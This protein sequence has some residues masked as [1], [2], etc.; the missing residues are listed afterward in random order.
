MSAEFSRPFRLDTLGIEPRSVAIEADAGERAALAERFALPGI[1]RLS[2][3]ARLSRHGD[4]VRAKGVARA[5][6]TQSCVVTSLPVPAA[7]EEA[8]ELVFRPQQ[9]AAAPDEEIELSEAEM[10]VIFYDGAAIDL[11]E[12]VAETVSLALD[13]FP[14]APEAEAALREAGVSSEEEARARSSPFAGLKDKLTK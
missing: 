1:E 11:G 13:P 9:E 2:A 8:F 6:V 7:I 4:E 12:A 3:K 5:Q 10:D 14:R